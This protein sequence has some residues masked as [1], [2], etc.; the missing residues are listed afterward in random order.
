M[1]H[2]DI[3][4][5]MREA[6]DRQPDPG[7]AYDL[8]KHPERKAESGTPAPRRGKSPERENAGPLDRYRQWE[9]EQ[10]KRQDSLGEKNREGL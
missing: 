3:F 10:E 5:K 6:V 9:R 1:P 8:T 7:D 4:R 2:E